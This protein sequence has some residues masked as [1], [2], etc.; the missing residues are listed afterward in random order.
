VDIAEDGQQAVNM[1]RQ[2][3]YD[4]IFMDCNMPVLDGYKASIKI[5]HDQ[6]ATFY[7]CPIIALTAN[8][9]DEVKLQTDAAG[10]D[11]V[12]TKPISLG[13]FKQCLNKW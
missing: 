9:A 10:M 3:H 13:K 7:N 11:D 1:A 6:Q 4:L 5:R 2:T 8:T 12:L